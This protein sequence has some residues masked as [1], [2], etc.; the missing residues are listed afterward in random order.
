MKRAINILR[1]GNR[2]DAL[3]L[4]VGIIALFVNALGVAVVLS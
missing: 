1:T 3:L 4:I 2:K